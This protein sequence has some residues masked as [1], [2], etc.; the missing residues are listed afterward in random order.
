MAYNYDEGSALKKLKQQMQGQGG[1][2]QPKLQ[3]GQEMRAKKKEEDN[4]DWWELSPEEFGRKYPTGAAKKAAGI[5]GTP[6]WDLPDD[7]KLEDL[8]QAATE[9]QFRQFPPY[10]TDFAKRRYGKMDRDAFLR[11][12]EA[13]MKKE[14]PDSWMTESGYTEN[15]GKNLMEKWKNRL[16][17]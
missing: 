13:I 11:Q 4:R 14:D 17:K 1:G 10:V 16:K 5:P 15:A 3:G 7:A 12:A 8:H 6:W 9:N 2:G